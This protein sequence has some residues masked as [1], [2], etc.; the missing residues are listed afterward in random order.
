MSEVEEVK[1]EEPQMYVLLLNPIFGRAE[2]RIAVAVADSVDKLKEFVE[3]EKVDTWQDV[4]PNLAKGVEH[5]TYYKTFKKG[6]PL[7]NFNQPDANAYAPIPS[8]A[9]VLA[10]EERKYTTWLNNLIKV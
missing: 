1:K 8:L 3:K 2:A 9:K 4:L 5:F 6:G 10:D 7:E